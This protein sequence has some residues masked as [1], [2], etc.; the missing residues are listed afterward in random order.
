LSCDNRQHTGAAASNS[1]RAATLNTAV[2]QRPDLV[3]S[4]RAIDRVLAVSSTLCPH[5]PSRLHHG[6]QASVVDQFVP[7]G[8]GGWCNVPIIRRVAQSDPS[9]ADSWFAR[10]ELYLS[11]RFGTNARE[12]C[13]TSCVILKSLR[14]MPSSCCIDVVSTIVGST[15]CGSWWWRTSP[16]SDEMLLFGGLL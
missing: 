3:H 15:R 14:D 7:S 13:V 6:G 16:L 1:R 11:R 8:A 10:G 9:V 5:C 2:Q 12:A 4:G